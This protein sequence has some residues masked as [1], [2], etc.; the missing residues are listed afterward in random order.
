MSYGYNEDDTGI[1]G[2]SFRELRVL[3]EVESTPNLSQRKIAG[4][5]GIAVGVA[6]VLIKSL[7]TKGYVRASRVTWKRWA[8]ILTPAGVAR[9]VQLTANYVD[10]F[11]DH[12]RKV[13]SLV[14]ET[15][16]V[17]DIGPDSAVAIYGTTELGELMFL[18]VRD[19]GV[20]NIEFLDNAA[21]DEFLGAP[22]KSLDSIEIHKYV[23]IMVAFSSDIETRRQRLVD[24]GVPKDRITT[25]LDPL[26]SERATNGSKP[27]R[28]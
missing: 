10:R 27:T 22:V 5:V 28:H 1:A 26:A 25:I 7:V 24:L 13:R 20:K 18:A 14:R 2:G 9:K 19:G 8:Y 12:Y 21:S 6:N 4:S 11:L 15:L 16:D 3:E 23:K 17:T